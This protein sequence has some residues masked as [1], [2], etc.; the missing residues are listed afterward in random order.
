MRILIVS[1]IIP[2]VEGG[3]TL[4]VDWLQQNFEKYGYKAD[5]LKIPFRSHYAEMLEQMLALR[6]LDVADRADRLIAI[7]TPSYLIQHPQKLLWFIHHHR[8]AYDLW[9]TEY[10]DIPNT[11]EGLSIRQAIIHSDNLAFKE[12]KKIFTNSKIVSKRLKDFNGIDSEVLYPPIMHPE[13]YYCQ[14]YG[15]YIFYPS[16][17]I[18]HK[19]QDLAIEAMRYTKTDVKLVIAGNPE[20]LGYLNELE[21]IV[22]KFKLQEKVKV[23]GRWISDD[24]K[25]EFFSDSLGG[26]YIPYDED[27]Y[28]YPTLEAY[29]SE[30]PVVTCSDSGGTLEI[31]EDNI[32]GYVAD[33]EPQALAEAF[34]K[35]YMNKQNA[36][37]MG[38][39]GFDKA[40][41]MDISWD[42]VIRRFTE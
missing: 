30:K 2:F 15:D 6:L 11:T 7:R 26:L 23:I 16:R 27:S 41:A 39:S 24:E 14:T 17:L 28:G 29:H 4:I 35:L 34:D 25:I 21:N 19:R 32:N 33:P 1:T 31:I 13:R 3:S 36:K 22:K 5:V 8:G 40:M 12:S 9:G 38:R 37:K 10:Q 20:S 42:K 18:R